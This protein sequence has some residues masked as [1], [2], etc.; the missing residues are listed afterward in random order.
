MVYISCLPQSYILCA[1]YVPISQS[2]LGTFC[3]TGFNLVCEICVVIFGKLIT[4][5]PFY[6]IFLCIIWQKLL[7]RLKF[8]AAVWLKWGAFCDVNPAKSNTALFFSSMYNQCTVEVYS[9]YIV[10]LTTILV[11]MQPCIIISRPLRSASSKP[12]Y[13]T[14]KCCN[15]G[16]LCQIGSIES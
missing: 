5:R 6:W 10:L 2:K 13:S 16:S 4:C 8:C 3:Y 7:Y 12:N 15:F 1:I 11:N 14:I 9:E